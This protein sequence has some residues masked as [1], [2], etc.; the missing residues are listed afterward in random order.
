MYIFFQKIIEY[1]LLLCRISEVA[2]RLTI[3]CYHSDNVYRHLGVAV[4]PFR[5]SVR[6]RSLRAA[7][8]VTIRSI[9]NSIL[10]TSQVLML[11]REP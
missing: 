9:P 5:M 1:L 7:H 3:T 6:Q 8:P 11:I 10:F 4:E 2:D